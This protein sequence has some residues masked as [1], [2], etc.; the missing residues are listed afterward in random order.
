MSAAF[1]AASQPPSSTSTFAR[2]LSLT[3]GIGFPG[4]VVTNIHWR[5][6]S[7]NKDFEMLRPEKSGFSQ[8][9]GR[10][11]PTFPA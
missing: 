5:T 7:G 8:P 10:I 4:F 9:A 11:E 1:H 2:T 3:C 6:R